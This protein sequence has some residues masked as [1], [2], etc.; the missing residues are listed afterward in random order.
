MT[1]PGLGMQRARLVE[2]SDAESKQ[3]TDTKGKAFM[4]VLKLR[5]ACTVKRAT[6]EQLDLDPNAKG[7][8]PAGGT[9]L[10]AAEPR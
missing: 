7:K 8:G 2:M 6:P 1:V 3:C 9:G 5:Y 4:Q 10:E